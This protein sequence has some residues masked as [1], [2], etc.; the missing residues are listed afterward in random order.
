MVATHPQLASLED[1]GHTY[2]GRTLRVLKLSSGG[3]GKAGVLMEAA[4]H[5]AEW[6]APAAA[7]YAIDQLTA[8]AVQNQEML[9]IADWYILP[10]LNMDGYVFTWTEVRTRSVIVARW[11]P[12]PKAKLFI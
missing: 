7:L 1:I 9:D 8:F 6:L 12:K 3:A 11:F 10:V 4:I 5:S 2:E